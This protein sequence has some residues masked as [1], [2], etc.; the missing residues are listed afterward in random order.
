MSCLFRN[1]TKIEDSHL[2]VATALEVYVSFDVAFVDEATHSALLDALDLEERREV[3]N[4][5][6][7][8]AMSETVPEAEDFT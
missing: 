7:V 2:V 1:I 8:E 4:V 5:R 6:E 3:E